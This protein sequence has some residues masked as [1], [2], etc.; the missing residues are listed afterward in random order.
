[1]E[2]LPGLSSLC[3]R[4]GAGDRAPKGAGAAGVGEGVFV[5]VEMFL[6]D[7]WRAFGNRHQ[8]CPGNRAC[9][10]HSVPDAFLLPK[11]FPGSSPVPGL[12]STDVLRQFYGGFRI[13]ARLSAFP[14]GEGGSIYRVQS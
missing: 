3:P 9:P 2:R 5:S 12:E 7:V 10:L 11:E 8:L 6:W 4:V 13:L 14:G 1:M